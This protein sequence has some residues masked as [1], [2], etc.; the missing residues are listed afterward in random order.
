[1]KFM[2]GV[3]DPSTK[4][5]DIDKLTK[6]MKPKPIQER[7]HYT[8]GVGATL[9][10]R[11]PIYNQI[12]N[13][14]SKKMMTDNYNDDYGFYTLKY[15][16][17]EDKGPLMVKILNKKKTEGRVGI[18]SIEGTA[19]EGLDYKKVNKILD[20]KEGEDFKSISVDIVA[21]S[22]THLTL[23]TTPYV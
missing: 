22:Y 8:R 21:V 10:G 1:M 6:K 9:S 20:F 14:S 16:I 3:Q 4:K 18:R 7:L 2:E 23:P 5:I 17:K 13:T 15:A 11:K 19:T 12:K